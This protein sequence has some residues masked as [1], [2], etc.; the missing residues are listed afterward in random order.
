MAGWQSSHTDPANMSTADKEVS[1]ENIEENDDEEKKL[2]EIQDLS[3]LSVAS[4]ASQNT[5]PAFGDDLDK[6]LFVVEVEVEV[7]HTLG[8]VDEKEKTMMATILPRVIRHTSRPHTSIA[9]YYS[10][11]VAV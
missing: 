2:P 10:Y 8:T 3:W 9:Y 1:E 4:H 11:W 6:K 7:E 5:L